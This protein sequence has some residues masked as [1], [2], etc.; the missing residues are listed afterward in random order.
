MST[1]WGYHMMLDCAGCPIELITNED[2][3]L[4]FNRELVKRIDMEAYGEPQLKYFAEHDPDKA[5]YTLLQLISTSNICVH[6]VDKNGA[7]YADVFSC[8]EFDQDTVEN[9]L[10]EFFKPQTVNRFFRIRDAVNPKT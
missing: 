6:F 9:T 10:R 8:K 2:N 5:G 4:K 7:L 1:Y 3:I